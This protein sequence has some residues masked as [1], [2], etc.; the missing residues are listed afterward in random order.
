[1][2][3]VAPRKRA[4]RSSSSAVMSVPPRTIRP[5]VGASRPAMRPRR[6]DLP[7]P[8]GPEIATAWPRAIVNEVG[9]RIVRG[10]A[11]LGTVRDTSTRSIIS[12]WLP[13]AWDLVHE[14]AQARIELV[15]DD[16]RPVRRRVDAVRLIERG[17]ARD[18]FEQERHERDL[19]LEL[20]GQLQEDVVKRGP[21]ILT[22]VRRRFH[23]GKQDG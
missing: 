7:L 8:D 12:L 20:L 15:G 4:S 17:V 22:E 5:V 10:P 19:S 16:L 1:M 6:V 9:C 2:P 21:V 3:I 13:R 14:I 18:A 11:P 23:A